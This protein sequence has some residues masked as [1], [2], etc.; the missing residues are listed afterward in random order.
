MYGGGREYSEDVAKLIDQEVRELVDKAYE[1]AKEIL[2]S[3]KDYVEALVKKLLDQ[4]VVS[5]QEFEEM[6]KE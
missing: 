2:R 1:D 6:F 4:E 3:K 5:E